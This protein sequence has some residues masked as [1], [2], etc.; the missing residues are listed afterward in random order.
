MIVHQ[1]LHG[2]SRGHRRLAESVTLTPD[3]QHRLDLLSDLS[4]YP[5]GREFTP[6]LSG[7]PNGR[8]YVLARTAP[9]LGAERDG[10][11]WTHSLLLPLSEAVKLH[12]LAAAVRVLHGERTPPLPTS[13]RAARE[14]DATAED[15]PLGGGAL[16]QLLAG[17]FGE[18]RRP[19]VWLD[20][21]SAV[22][23]ALHLWRTLPAE[24]RGSLAFCT[25]ALQGRWMDGRPF[26]W[27]GMEPRRVRHLG[28]LAA[29]GTFAGENPAPSGGDALSKE[30]GPLADPALA[31]ECWR[32]ARGRGLAP[33]RVPIP[34]IL[35]YELLRND[36][37]GGRVACL[38]LAKRHEA[39]ADEIA[40]IFSEL[41]S[42]P[43]A[44][45]PRER[46][47]RALQLLVRLADDSDAELRGRVSRWLA[48]ML[49]DPATLGESDLLDRLLAE[50]PRWS[51]EISAWLAEACAEAPP[52]QAARLVARHDALLAVVLARL[53][54]DERRALVRAWPAGSGRPVD[55]LV[56]QAEALGDLALLLELPADGVALAAAARISE[57]DPDSATA[58]ALLARVDSIDLLAWL[59]ASPERLRGP[60]ARPILARLES[61]PAFVSWLSEADIPDSERLELLSRR[62]TRMA[63]QDRGTAG[64]VWRLAQTHPAADR[65]LVEHALGLLGRHIL[66][67]TFEQ[68]TAWRDARWAADARQHLAEPLIKAVLGG[69]VGWISSPVFATVVAKERERVLGLLERA[70]GSATL[71]ILAR[72]P[73][74]SLL[75]SKRAFKLLR[76]VAGD[77][78]WRHPDSW[79][80]IL[81]KLEQ[82]RSEEL[83]SLLYWPTLE[84][85][86][87]GAGEF[88]A[89]LLRII[90]PVS[91]EE[92]P[93]GMLARAVK[94]ARE[95]FNFADVDEWDTQRQLRAAFVQAW[96]RHRWP[97]ETLR[98]ACH[99]E[100]A[101]QWMLDEVRRQPNASA[102]SKRLGDRGG[103]REKRK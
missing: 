40:L 32:R 87:A 14:L 30:L 20:P 67:S 12:S 70:D 38:D 51:T 44:S 22:A 78:P 25:N 55:R 18:S 53:S 94:R 81:D 101:W 41:L 29:R 62:A 68:D 48:P 64:L 2:Y 15:P 21:P 76:D 86:D 45:T 72:P 99:N 1:V 31:Q 4:G 98:D 100:D 52:D 9:D 43:A 23:A 71:A 73:G 3:E 92:R 19:L 16:R 89:N 97:P 88:A 58:M 17:W 47:T 42:E 65:A 8:F 27:L 102:L 80:A 37:F 90:Y 33:G 49:S 34:L 26:D 66:E 13:I 56:A 69:A 103:G 28:D 5:D 96:A 36:G 63:L 82:D 91:H 60:M 74:D 50:S 93:R 11:V 10:T 6:Y 35:R 7:Y 79:L 83:A 57:R 85:P 84:S 54:T 46:L 39:S 95:I 77:A 75:S 61:E 24:H 59:S